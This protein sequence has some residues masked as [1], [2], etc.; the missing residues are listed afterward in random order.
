MF[1]ARMGAKTDP[2]PLGSTRTHS[3]PARSCPGSGRLPRRICERDTENRPHAADARA[4]VWFRQ[5][6]SCFRLRTLKILCKSAQPA[7]GFAGMIRLTG[8]ALF[9]I[10]LWRAQQ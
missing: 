2:F 10:A 6:Y 4:S 3:I 8:G 1:S 7:G 5:T 9:S